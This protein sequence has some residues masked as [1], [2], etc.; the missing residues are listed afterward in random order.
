MGRRRN[1]VLGPYVYAV[2]TYAGRSY[3]VSSDGPRFLMMKA[4]GVP[5]Q[6]EDTPGI[7][8]VQNWFEE[9]KRLTPPR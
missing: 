3:D 7:T 2:A 1:V 4:A 8:V 5:H 6:K 9:L